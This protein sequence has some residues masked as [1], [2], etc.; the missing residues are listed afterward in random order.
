MMLMQASPS[1]V[2]FAFTFSGQPLSQMKRAA[3]RAVKYY[4]ST[5]RSTPTMMPEGP[6]V[7]TLVDQLQPAVGMRLVDF[8]FLSGRYVRN[9]RPKGFESFAR[10]M[11][12]LTKR[13]KHNA[14]V[15]GNG[16]GENIRKSNNMHD[17][18]DN[19][20]VGGTDIVRIL[21]CKGKFIYLILDEG[22]YDAGSENDYQRSIWITLGMTGRF[23][24]EEEVIKES[25]RPRASNNN[26]VKEGPRWYMELMDPSSRQK[27]KIYFR[28]E[29]NFGTLRFCLSAKELNDKLESLGPD[30]LDF[31]GTT[32]DVFLQA[33]DQSKPNRN[34]CKFLMDQ[35]VRAKS[36]TCSFDAIISLSSFQICILDS[37]DAHNFYHNSSLPLMNNFANVED[38]WS[39]VR[40]MLSE[41]RAIVIIHI[42]SYNFSFPSLKQL[43]PCR[44]SLPVENRSV[45]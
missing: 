2:S 15:D 13:E 38:F 28:D 11:T 23:V 29:R 32:E 33:M 25:N 27:R 22:E 36:I 10:S 31:E 6:E 41:L 24:S 18:G 8:Q 37:F 43:H 12:P 14:E 19:E 3:P 1:I 45:C 26:Q 42:F 39:R 34:I 9:G 16:G 5:R 4:F 35:G 21:S 30:L 17:D 44:R 20:G 40:T 7:R